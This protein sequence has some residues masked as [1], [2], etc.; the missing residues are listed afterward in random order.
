[1]SSPDPDVA[2]IPEDLPRVQPPSAGFIV[3]L[4]VVP[5]VIVAAIVG[6]WLLFGKL[7]GGD[8]DWRGLVVELQNP[9]EHRRWR[10][11]NGLAQILSADQKRGSDG[12]QLATNRELAQ[13]L[14]E[15][16][17][18]ELKRGGQTEAELNYQAFVA[19]TLGLF[20]LPEVVFPALQQAMQPEHDREV[21]KNALGSV[22]VMTD[23]M[24]TAGTGNPSDLFAAELLTVSSDGDPLIR[25]LSAFALGL[26]PQEAA[27]ERLEV[28][29]DDTDADTRINAAIGL[30]RSGDVGGIRVFRDVLREAMHPRTPRSDD[31]YEQFVALK[32][33]L[34]A[35][36]RLAAKFT[37]DQRQEL[38]PL[39]EPIAKDYREPKIRIEARTALLA[40]QA[41]KGP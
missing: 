25:R 14:S 6:V 18:T 5:G 36:D 34:T 33:A 22:A 17:R 8:Q 31:E 32:N 26:F 1:M 2:E 39:L 37:P 15:V 3:Q 29:L 10:A 21:R 20:D 24:S 4:F 23:R 9:N 30:S 16:L 40:L 12:Q 41:V 7:A 27:R 28:L 13:A 35:I 38:I 11:A 19:R